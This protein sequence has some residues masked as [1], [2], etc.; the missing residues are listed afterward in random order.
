MK[1][2][3]FSIFMLCCSFA[4][5]SASFAADNECGRAYGQSVKSCAESL[6]FLAPNVRAGAQKACVEDAKISKEACQ[7]GVNTCLEDC[8]TSYQSSLGA[9]ESSYQQN[10]IYCDGDTVCNAY[11]LNQKSICESASV[12]TLNSCTA[13]CQQ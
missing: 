1:T 2:N 10:L 6:E 13:S 12:D 3:I 5:A 8:N 4:F 9:C 11:Y 7:S